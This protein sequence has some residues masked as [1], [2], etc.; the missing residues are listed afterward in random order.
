[1]KRA[2][3]HYE[4]M[5]SK[6]GAVVAGYRPALPQSAIE[7]LDIGCGDGITADVILA[8]R[9]DVKLTAIDN[10]PKMVKQAQRNLNDWHRN[11]E[12]MIIQVDALQYLRGVNV[13]RFDVVAS[14]FTLHNF[15]C[16]YRDEVLGE[17]FR[18]LKPGGVFVNADK[19]APDGQQQFEALVIQLERF[20]EA[21]LPLGKHEL[22]KDWVLHNVADQAP[23]RVMKEK[24]SIRAMHDLGFVDVDVLNRNNMEAVLVGTKPR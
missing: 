1:M 5:E 18:V 11:R 3:P 12:F 7:V 4:E 24:D 10:E 20:F 13:P 16:S 9:G 19:Y 2:Y 14:A 22:L 15:Q 23:D 8:S 17:T 21:F 6:I